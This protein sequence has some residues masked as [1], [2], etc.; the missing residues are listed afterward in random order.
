MMASFNLTSSAVA[1]PRF[2]E[3]LHL[4]IIAGMTPFSL[5]VS[6]SAKSKFG[7]RDV[8]FSFLRIFLAL[9]FKSANAPDQ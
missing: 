3:V 5:S 7:A 9:F 4:T 8:E 6:Q 1:S 2:L